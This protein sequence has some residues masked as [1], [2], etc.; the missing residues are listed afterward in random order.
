[1]AIE[2][3]SL[4]WTLHVYYYT[5]MLQFYFQTIDVFL[6]CLLLGSIRLLVLEGESA[7]ALI[8]LMILANPGL[9]ASKH[10]AVQS[11]DRKGSASKTS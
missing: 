10:Y 7:R 6:Q 4:R 5:I 8:E 3:R 9:V 1:M 2:A 11:K